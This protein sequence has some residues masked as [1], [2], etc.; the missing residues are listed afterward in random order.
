MDGASNV[1]G[2]EASIILKGPDG[3]LIYQSLR[4]NFKASN[5]QVKYESFIARLS[6]RNKSN[7][8]YYEE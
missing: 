2:S 3:L 7:L 5:N 8:G 6:K 1:K 4:F